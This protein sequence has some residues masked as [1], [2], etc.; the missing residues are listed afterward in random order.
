MGLKGQL[1]AGATTLQRQTSVFT[2][3]GSQPQFT[4]SVNIG[5]TFIFTNVKAD[6]P[7][8]VRFYGN[9]SSRNTVSELTRPFVSQSISGSIALLADVNLTTN[10]VF[11]LTPPLFGVNLDSPISNAIYYTV[12]TGS[13]F[14]GSNTISIS[15]FNLE[16]SSVVNI[17]NVITRES[18]VVT[19][20]IG[21]GQN[22]TGSITTPKTYLLY[23]IAPSAI[24][25]RL[26]LYSD[27]SYRDN[28]AEVSRSFGVE[29][30]ASSGIIADVYMD[31]VETSSLTPIVLGRNMESIPTSTT[32][33]TITNYSAASSVTSSVY[34][35]SL[36]D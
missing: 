36:E 31:T 11:N 21:T 4:G 17:A 5:R 25:L 32:Y 28:V 14:S 12:D 9:I 6:T 33:Y 19:A 35:F 24:P 26:R 30:S 20:S 1:T 2:V 27:T 16:D 29:P 23:Q 3:S 22:F 10:E 8:R 13:F 18:F 34:V 7:C 15:S